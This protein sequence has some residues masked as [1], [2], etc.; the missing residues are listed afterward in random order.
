MADDADRAG[1]NTDKF[2]ADAI[3]A[4]SDAAQRRTLIPII[5]ELDKT[6]YGVCHYCESAIKPGHLFCPTDEA[7]PDKSCAF[8]WEHERARKKD[9]GL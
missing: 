2:E 3:K 8:E 4:I 1:D 7:E 5:Q 6:R 9:L